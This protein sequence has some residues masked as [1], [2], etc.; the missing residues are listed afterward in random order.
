MGGSRQ[1]R[2]DHFSDLTPVETFKETKKSAAVMESQTCMLCLML[3]NA[4]FII[5][6]M[7]CRLVTNVFVD[8]LSKWSF[9]RVEAAFLLSL[10]TTPSRTKRSP[11]QWF[12]TIHYSPILQGVVTS[13]LLP[14]TFIYNSTK[15]KTQ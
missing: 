9:L 15:G 2:K 11:W 10:Q 6:C 3:Q 13:F 8:F 5:K 12:P 1:T 14:H 4:S 7:S